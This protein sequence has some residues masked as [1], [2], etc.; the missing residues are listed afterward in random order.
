MKSSK[1]SES[2]SKEMKTNKKK[3]CCHGR[4]FVILFWPM[5]CSVGDQIVNWLSG[6]GVIILGATLAGIATVIIL[7]SIALCIARSKRRLNG[8]SSSSGRHHLPMTKIELQR[9]SEETSGE[10]ATACHPLLVG[11][12]PD[13]LCNDLTIQHF[14]SEPVRYVVGTR[15]IPF[16]NWLLARAVVFM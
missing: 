5:I 1:I 10:S 3:P 16:A 2:I 8:R 4:P 13:K 6:G 12:D 15:C 7:L 11:A 9:S 14:D